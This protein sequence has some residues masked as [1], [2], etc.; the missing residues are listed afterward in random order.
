[1]TRALIFGGGGQL[2]HYMK[3]ILSEKNI[4]VISP[5][6]QDVDISDFYSVSNIIRE[7]AP[8]EIYNFAAISSIMECDALPLDTIQINTMG[9]ANILEGIRQEKNDILFFQAGSHLELDFN[10]LYSITKGCASSII[11]F[12][13]EKYGINAYCGM[14]PHCE[15]P[16][17]PKKF[18]VGRVLDWVRELKESM[19]ANNIESKNFEFSTN[20]IFVIYHNEIIWRYPKIKLGNL[21]N[22]E[23]WVTC[24]DAVSMIYHY[25][26]NNNDDYVFFLDRNLYFTPGN[27]L[28]KI[29]KKNGLEGNWKNYYVFDPVKTRSRNIK[30]EEPV[31][32]S[33]EGNIDNFINFITS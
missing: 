14:L 32:F 30:L 22:K 11:S 6:S 21:Y 27:I 17:R 1:M 5:S 7:V 16:I 28:E 10:N 25:I 19:E 8:D 3:L 23:S 31:D 26:H 4:D 13:R 12:Y 9:V 18:F 33:L 20:E 15:S 29:L 2:G 24:L